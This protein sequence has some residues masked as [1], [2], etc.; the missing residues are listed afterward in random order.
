MNDLIHRYLDGELSDDEARALYDAITSDPAL[1]A[2]LRNWERMLRGAAA[3][4]PGAP[5]ADF[6]D[7]VMGRVLGRRGSVRRALRALFAVPAPARRAG[8]AT[9]V[10]TF[11][12]GGGATRG[13]RGPAGPADAPP[14]TE[15][16]AAATDEGEMRVVRLVYASGDP[17]VNTVRV[18]GTFNEWNPEGIT[19][20]RKGDLWTAVLILPRGTY[21][22]MFVEDDSRWV[23]D[24]LALQT[25]DD[26]FGRKNAVL[27][28]TL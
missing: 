28:L 15:T 17:R 10:R 24:P 2:E 7:R 27:D 19:M 5:S 14:G 18:A 25:R 16:T 21:E 12:R 22:Y 8:A 1:E 13:G 11:A 26:G 9:R 6:T 20:E 4:E 3:A 23:T